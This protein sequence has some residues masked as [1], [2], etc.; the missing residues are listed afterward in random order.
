MNKDTTAQPDKKKKLRSDTKKLVLTALFLAF[1][2]V[3]P[4]LTGQIKSVGAML[5]PMHIPIILC[6]FI[7]GWQYGLII[8]IIAPLFRSLVFGMPVLYPSAVCMSFELATYGAV[9]GLMLKLFPK[10]KWLVYPELLIAMIAGRLV[11]GLS[12]FLALGASTEAFTLNAF[13]AGSV[14]NSIPGIAIQIVIIP[15]LVILINKLYK[16]NV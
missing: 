12:M 8:G 1:A 2:L 13:L 7:C 10:N 6:G 11:W 14:L 15:P 3:L 16:N 5:C 9:A 4:F